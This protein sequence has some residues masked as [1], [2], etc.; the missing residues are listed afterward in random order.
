[1]VANATRKLILLELLAMLLLAAACTYWGHL[2]WQLGLAIGIGAVVLVRL[3]ISAN[4]FILAWRYSSVTPD[5]HLLNWRQMLSLFLYEFY[6]SMWTSSYAMP[7][8]A[9][10]KRVIDHANGLPVLLIHGYGCNSGA[11]HAMSTTLTNAHVTHHA[12]NLEP[13]FSD[14]DNYVPMI[15]RA[16][17]TLCAETGHARIIIVAHSMGGLATRA[18]MRDHG[19]GRIAQLVTLGSPHHGTG[20]ANFGVGMNCRQMHWRGNAVNGTPSQWLRK[21]DSGEDPATRA[22]IVSIYSH[23]DNIVSPQVSSQLQ[24]ARN[25]EYQG[26]GHVALLLHPLIHAR[27][28]AEIRNASARELAALSA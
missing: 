2:P 23:H 28:L 25:I 27:V 6:A 4:N 1:M 26:I 8:K 22:R 19:N 14:I 12:I 17:E 21:L 11:W 15:H 16:V 13:V 3:T 10:S 18:Y 7:F 5:E 24:G 20:I 9:F